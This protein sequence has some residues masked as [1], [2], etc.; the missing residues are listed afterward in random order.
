[1][2][3]NVCTLGEILEQAGC[4][5]RG[6]IRRLYWTESANIDWAA[7]LADPLQFDPTNQQI[8]GYTM[9]GGAVFNKLEFERKD[10]FY[11]FT[12]TEESGV[13]TLNIPMIFRGKN[14]TQRNTLNLATLCCDIVAHIYDN[15]GIQ[16]VVG[17]DYDGEVFDPIVSKLK[18]TRVLDSSGQLGQSDARDEMD[19]GGESFYSP[20][21][22]NV[23]LAD[24][25]LT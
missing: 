25:P 13:W 23:P 9:I 3:L 11:D 20:L 8:L 2:P 14:L 21:F 17:I 24:I 16:R 19:L 6:G 1:M 4:N 12:Y 18:V 10:A 7:M 15:S 5:F 22:A